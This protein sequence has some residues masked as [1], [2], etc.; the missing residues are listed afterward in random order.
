MRKP[1][2]SIVAI[3]MLLLGAWPTAAGATFHEMSIREVYAGSEAAK[4]S[5]YVELQ[6][7]SP[8]QNFVGGHV[9][10][11][12]NAAG[13]VTS[14][15]TF[16]GDV[17]NGANQSTI[18]LAT[19][20][21]ETEFGLVADTGLGAGALDPAGGAVCWE[22]LDCVSWGSFSG[23]LPSPA[24]TPA[25][26]I[27][28]GM[29]L[30]RTIAPLC[31]TALDSGDDH[32]NSAA[33]FFAVFPAPRP[34]SVAPG[35]RLCGGSSGGFFGG[36]GGGGG[37]NGGQKKGAPRTKLR[38]KPGK[39]THD[40]TPT[41]RFSSN[42]AGST[43]QCKLDGKAYKGCRSPFTAKRLGFGPHTF[44][45]RARDK[46]GKLDPSPASYSFKVLRP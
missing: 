21:A 9:L 23:P 24:G 37:G 14:T 25:P 27:P 29:A 10:K 31:P 45:V 16:P 13:G 20:A 28:S 30:R 33:D 44:K 18:L 19:P 8:G 7:W 32:D 12:Y 42:E 26:A 38:G 43:F 2:V 17:P 1:K 15:D 34:N 46:S 6:M 39:K 40:R 35:E 3:A 11:T 5:E 4:E 22:A 41:F 36:G